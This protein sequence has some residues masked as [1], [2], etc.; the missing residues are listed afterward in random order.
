MI[1]DM[2]RQQIKKGIVKLFVTAKNV[3]IEAGKW[4]LSRR[5]RLFKVNKIHEDGCL[6]VISHLTGNKIKIPPEQ[7]YWITP[8]EE[9]D[10]E[11]GMLLMVGSTEE[12]DCLV[13][14]M[15]GGQRSKI[16]VFFFKSNRISAIII[17]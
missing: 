15:W 5:K 3:S 14:R 12:A 6:T 4:Y 10:V 11:P 2:V 17:S 13:G 7:A 8:T 1:D 16:S 9:P